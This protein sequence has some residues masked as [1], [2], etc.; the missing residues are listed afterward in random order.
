[1]VGRVRKHDKYD[2]HSKLLKNGIDRGGA[3]HL[4]PKPL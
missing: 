1:M 4:L 3:S 2:K